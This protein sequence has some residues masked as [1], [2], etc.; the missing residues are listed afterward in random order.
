MS[1]DEAQSVFYDEFAIQFYDDESSPEERYLLLGVSDRSRILVVVHC[2][3]G[4]DEE[5]LRIIS[6]R[7]ATSSERNFYRGER[8]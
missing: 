8:Q 7:K 4:D 5:E 6:A 2:E 1:F 3:R